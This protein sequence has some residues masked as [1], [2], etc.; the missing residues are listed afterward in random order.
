MKAQEAL[1]RNI[2]DNSLR[3]RFEGR[4]EE[5]HLFRSP[6]A[7]ASRLNMSGCSRS[8]RELCGLGQTQTEGAESLKE[9]RLL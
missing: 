7:S 3:N 8:L 6:I 4:R 2:H 1:A 5:R 9:L